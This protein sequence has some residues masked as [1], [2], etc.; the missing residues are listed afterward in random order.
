MTKVNDIYSYIDS[1]APFDTAEG[2]DNVGM[3]VGDS[4]AEVT[5]AVV[6]L[7]IT[8]EVVEEAAEMGAELIISHH[9]VIF[10]PLRSI[11]NGSVVYHLIKHGITAICAHTNLDK[12]PVYG[13]NTQL[14]SAMNL[15]NIGIS[16]I[17]DILFEG[18]TCEPI[19]AKDFAET[20]RKNLA[21]ECVA[22]TEGKN[23]VRK[24]GLCSG[25]GGSEINAAIKSK[26]DAFVTGEMKHHE[27]LEANA[28][29]LSVYILGHYKSE[30]V[31]I[32]P[33]CE[34]LRAEF[35]DVLFVKSK[36]FTDKI[37]W[38]N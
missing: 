30:D 14:A 4:K 28:N 2:F 36:V 3:L 22:F 15:Q 20:I 29:G 21:C 19:S 10:S 7:D 34:K 1:F 32:E 35:K 37:Q 5:K 13:V 9:P 11:N 6:S 25:A 38:S 26:C 16:E 23:A 31:V 12:S 17:S 33:L 8:V 18:Y 27:I 24:V